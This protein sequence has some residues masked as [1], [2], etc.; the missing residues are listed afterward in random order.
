MM[1]YDNTKVCKKCRSVP[2][3]FSVNSFISL[4]PNRKKTL[5]RHFKVIKHAPEDYQ[6]TRI[7]MFFLSKG[8][9]FKKKKFIKNVNLFY[10]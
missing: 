9:V 5:E 8:Q 3:D 2:N 10:E 1:C 4:S 7:F 6:R